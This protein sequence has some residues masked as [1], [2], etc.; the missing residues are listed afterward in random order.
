MFT[1]WL[2]A[3]ESTTPIEGILNVETSFITIGL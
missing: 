2:L 3:L 1:V